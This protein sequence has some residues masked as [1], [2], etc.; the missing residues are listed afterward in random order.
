M[1]A[2]VWTNSFRKDY[3]LALKRNLDLKKIQDIIVLLANDK[4]LP[5]QSRPHKLRG[6]YDDFWECHIAPDWL[7]I[8]EYTRL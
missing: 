6:N 5:G 3:K 8:Y 4:G 2:V 7:L 1:R